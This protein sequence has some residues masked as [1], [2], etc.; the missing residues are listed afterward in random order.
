MFVWYQ[1]QWQLS[2]I[3]KYIIKPVEWVYTLFQ[4]QIQRQCSGM[5]PHS[6]WIWPHRGSLWGAFLKPSKQVR[7]PWLPLHAQRYLPSPPIT[8]LPW[9]LLLL[10]PLSWGWEKLQSCLAYSSQAGWGLVSAYNGNRSSS[11]GQGGI[12]PPC[13]WGTL[14]E[15]VL[16][17]INF[18]W[19][20]QWKYLQKLLGPGFSTISAEDNSVL[21]AIPHEQKVKY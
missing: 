1:A 21:F 10:S 14:R 11:D 16:K 2:K 12:P 13:T 3:T 18:Y 6:F 5:A 20:T 4:G 9:L 17:I 7:K 19:H 15:G 8:L